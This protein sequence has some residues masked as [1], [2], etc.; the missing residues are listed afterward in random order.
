M[1]SADLIAVVA[2]GL[3]S[4]ALIILIT[5]IVGDTIQ[6]GGQSRITEDFLFMYV[7]FP[8]IGLLTGS[9]STCCCGVIYRA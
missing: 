5:Q 6:V 3:I 1:D 8:V 2:A 4:L 7:L 9:S